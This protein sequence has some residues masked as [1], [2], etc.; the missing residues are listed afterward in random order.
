MI[1]D[2]S[3]E[4]S[5]SMYIDAP[6]NADKAYEKIMICK[7]LLSIIIFPF[8]NRINRYSLFSH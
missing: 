7:R 6:V 8:I 5:N 1:T 2:L 4:V 3:K